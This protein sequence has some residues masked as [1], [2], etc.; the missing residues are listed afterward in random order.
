LASCVD[1]VPKHKEDDFERTRDGCARKGT[2]TQM[3]QTEMTNF[4]VYTQDQPGLPDGTYLLE[5]KMPI[6]VNFGGPYT[7]NGKCWYILWLFG[8]FDIKFV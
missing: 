8:I 6:W 2:A 5:P 3:Q 1:C 7:Y 4:P